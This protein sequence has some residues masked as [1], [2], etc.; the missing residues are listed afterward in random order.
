MQLDGL[1]HDEGLKK[2]AFDLLDS[3]GHD[4]SQGGL[5]ET[6]AGQTD[7]RGGKTSDE[8]P[9]EG[10]EGTH[11]HKQHEGQHQRHPYDPKTEPAQE[12]VGRSDEEHSSHVASDR[13]PNAATHFLG[14]NALV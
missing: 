6:A 5:A 4:D 8:R 2:V 14:V 9:Q 12:R 3:D 1:T 11:K 7:E 10:N 13:L